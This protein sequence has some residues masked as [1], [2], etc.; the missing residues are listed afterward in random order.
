[1]INR[2]IKLHYY[3]KSTKVCE[4]MEQLTWITIHQD[5]Y[6]ELNIANE[7]LSYLYT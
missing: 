1:M 3:G 6:V 5:K 2:M 7:K 4:I